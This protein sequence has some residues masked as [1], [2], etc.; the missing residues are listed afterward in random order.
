MAMPVHASCPTAHMLHEARFHPPAK[1]LPDFPVCLKGVATTLNDPAVPQCIYPTEDGITWGRTHS[2]DHLV[3]QENLNEYPPLVAALQRELG[4]SGREISVVDAGANDGLSTRLF[5]KGLPQARVVSI[6]PALS[7]Y[8]MVLRNT[9]DLGPRVIAMR[10]AVWNSST[11]MA[12]SGSDLSAWSLSVKPRAEITSSTSSTSSTGDHL[13][14]GDRHLAVLPGITMSSLLDALCVTTTLDFLKMDIEGAEL[15]VL[16][17]GSAAWL[18][19]V[20]YF[21]WRRT[22]SAPRL[23]TT[24]AAHSSHRLL[25]NRPCCRVYDTGTFTWRRTGGPR[26]S[27]QGS[28]PS[29]AR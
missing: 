1:R 29:R 25:C 5:A 13:H 9:R 6:E 22:R 28:R 3:R 23:V 26:T 11:S 18:R 8:A 4:G 10:A 20:K 27:R 19:R 15:S 21:K 12:V 14:H 2:T 7:N 24:S 17:P 16:V